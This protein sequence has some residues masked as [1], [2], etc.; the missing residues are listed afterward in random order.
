MRQFSNLSIRHKLFYI[1]IA[2]VFLTILTFSVIISIR[3]SKVVEQ[4]AKNNVEHSII[5]AAQH[6]TTLTDDV[7]EAISAL[8]VLGYN[9]KDAVSM[10]NSIYKDGMKVEEIVRLAL[11]N[12]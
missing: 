6:I 3:S 4:L 8:Q 10:V 12:K 5:S 1:Y 7:N 11:K 2:I 9:N